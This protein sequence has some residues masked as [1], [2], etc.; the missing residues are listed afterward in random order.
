MKIQCIIEPTYQPTSTIVKDLDNVDQLRIKYN[1]PVFE[2][3]DE[4]LQS[5]LLSTTDGIII[6]TPHASH[7]T[8]GL[9]CIKAQLNIL[10]E[11]P[12]TTDVDEARLLYE[13]S[14]NNP[15]KIFQINNSANWRPRAKQLYDII[16]KRGEIGDVKHIHAYFGV[17]LGGLFEDPESVGWHAKTGNMKGNGFGWGQLSHTISFLLKIT[18]L[19]PSKAFAFTGNSEITGADIYTA[20]SIKCTNNA[21]ISISGVGV[22]PAYKSKKEIDNLIVGSLG[23]VRYQGLMDCDDPSNDIG[24][25]EL[26]LNNGESKTIEGFEFENLTVVPGPESIHS[27]IDGCMGKEGDGYYDG[28]NGLLGFLTVATIDAIYRSAISEMAENILI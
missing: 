18:G 14:I 26:S 8:I 19:T 1:C 11:K 6:C 15:T 23:R 27:F 12:M 3:I 9:K 24:S 20:I 17:N 2:T 21:T 5:D 4:F 25:L 22:C 13:A 16:L 10:M 28:A 7:A